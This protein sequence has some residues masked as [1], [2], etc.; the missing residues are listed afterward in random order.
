MPESMVIHKPFMH[1]ALQGPSKG[2]AS[3]LHFLSVPAKYFT[4]LSIFSIDFPISSQ[5]RFLVE[6]GNETEKIFIRKANANSFLMVLRIS[7]ISNN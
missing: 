5:L 3:N 4:V 2:W 1:F 6:P 7:Y